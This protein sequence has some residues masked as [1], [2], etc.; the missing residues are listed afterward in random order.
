MTS[1]GIRLDSW[2]VQNGYVGGREKAKELIAAGHVTVDGKS[3]TKA[4]F[5]VADNMTVKC[6]APAEK[7][8]GRG[9]YKLEKALDVS[10][11][12]V[13]GA[14]CMDVGASTGGFTDRM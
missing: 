11:V 5:H 9:G 3:V 12:S 4:A 8:V 2:L 13:D 14:V 1:D 6:T 7:Y 10:G